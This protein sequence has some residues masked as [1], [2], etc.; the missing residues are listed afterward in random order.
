MRPLLL[1]LALGCSSRRPVSG[2]APAAPD[3][4]WA[5][6][7]QDWTR[8]LKLYDGL[9]NALLVEATLW[10]QPLREAWADEVA[11]R[12]ALSAGDAL[13]LMQAAQAEAGAAHEVVFAAQ[14]MESVSREFGLTDA[15]P[16]RVAL[17]VNGRP[18]AGQSIER[19]DP[20]PSDAQ[21][22]LVVNAWSDLWIA[23]F[24]TDCG[25][26]GEVTLAVTG[27]QGR[28]E[29]AWRLGG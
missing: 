4:P 25:T 29:L 16:W 3:R 2:A 8:S 10:D 28:G 18:C 24:A 14:R 26:S 22:W 9:E 27:L 1:L 17:S 23:R 7:H 11:W 15:D 5:R 6:V 19:L 21:R 13:A 12:R 20:S